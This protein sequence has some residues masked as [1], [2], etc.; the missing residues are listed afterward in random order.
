MRTA[1]LNLVLF[2]TCFL[3]A[4]FSCQRFFYALPFAG[5]KVKRVT[6]YFFNYVLG[7]YLAFKTAKRIFEGLSLL[8]SNFCQRT[9]PPYS[10]KRDS[11][12]MASLTPFSQAQCAI[13][14]I[15]D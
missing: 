6:L 1:R 10:S 7:L 11:L 12:V 2:L 5:L 9:T 15:D 3:A 14:F 4:A 13:T 8:K